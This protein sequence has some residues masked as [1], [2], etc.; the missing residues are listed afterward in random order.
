MAQVRVFPHK[1]LLSY[2]NEPA[3][4]LRFSRPSSPLCCVLLLHHDAGA[5]LL[6]LLARIL[7]PSSLNQAY[8]ADC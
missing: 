4:S 8:F 6:P 2:V 3:T 1:S 7:L 5:Q